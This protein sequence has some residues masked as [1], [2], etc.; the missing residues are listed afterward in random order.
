MKHGCRFTAASAK[1]KAVKHGSQS[2]NVRRSAPSARHPGLNALFS[3]R[4]DRC[5]CSCAGKGFLDGGRR[6]MF[7]E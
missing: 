3:A 7:S 6:G 1:L 5:V 2:A 4:H